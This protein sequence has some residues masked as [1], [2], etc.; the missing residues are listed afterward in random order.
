MNGDL[1]TTANLLGDPGRAAITGGEPQPPTT[2]VGALAEF[3]RAFNE[4]DLRL[5]EQNWDASPDSVMDNP[6]GGIMRGWPAIRGVYERL[7]SGA[8]R[9]TVEFFDYT[10]HEAADAFWAIGRERGVLAQAGQPDLALAIRTSRLFQRDTTG[11]WRQ[12]H[13]H[14]S[15]D[16][17]KLLIDY[18]ARLR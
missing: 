15:I 7:F 9:V 5:M 12:A 4:R 3:Y 13:H 16:D 14:G 6:L 10:V 11:R 18:K 1:S 17:P 8:A 2:P